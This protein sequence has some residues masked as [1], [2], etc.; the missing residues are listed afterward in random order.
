MLLIGIVL[1]VLAALIHFAGWTLI[2]ALVVVG[3][4]CIVLGIVLGERLPR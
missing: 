3:I 1:L 2:A 4:A